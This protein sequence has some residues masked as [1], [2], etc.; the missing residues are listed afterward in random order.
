MAHVSLVRTELNMKI[1]KH[2]FVLSAVTLGL[3]F[4]AQASQL[5]ASVYERF[6]TPSSYSFGSDGASRMRRDL[7]DRGFQRF[8]ANLRLGYSENHQQFFLP[9]PRTSRSGVEDLLIGAVHDEMTVVLRP[10]VVEDT[11][12]EVLKPRMDAI[13]T[14][15]E[16]DRLV[17]SLGRYFAVYAGIL[18]KH[19]LEEF[20]IPS[21]LGFLLTPEGLPSLNSLARSIRMRSGFTRFHLSLELSTDDVL[22][23]MQTRDLV[24]ES[25]FEGLLKPFSRLRL[26]LPDSMGIQSERGY[27]ALEYR[28]RSTRASLEALLPNREYVLSSVT[29]PS[30]ES[31]EVKSEGRVDCLGNSRTLDSEL[32]ARRLNDYLTLQKSLSSD[33][34]WA[35]FEVNYGLT[36]VEPESWSPFSEF[37]FWNLSTRKI[38]EDFLKDEFPKNENGSV[39]EL[40]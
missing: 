15:G 32:Q 20:V 19:D 8:T 27:S 5:S 16:I 18:R 11:S 22:V 14:N 31:F 26:F 9:K 23:L 24:G 28:I 17:D 39:G 7:Y 33:L 25:E 13:E 29:L 21:Q 3:G 6:Y 30:C 40:P 37:M 10:V 36:D 35:Y 38:L 1:F 34:A 12:S 2:F 4:E